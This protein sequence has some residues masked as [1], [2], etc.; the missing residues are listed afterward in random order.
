M[1]FYNQISKF[2]IIAL[3]ITDKFRYKQIEYVL[4]CKI[5]KY[6]FKKTLSKFIV[7]TKLILRTTSE[8]LMNKFYSIH[9]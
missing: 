2:F 9:V 8:F 6:K 5:Y 1:L 3:I 4:Y 7:L